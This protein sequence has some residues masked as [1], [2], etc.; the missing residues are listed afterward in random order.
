MYKNVFI[1]TLLVSTL[2]WIVQAK[3]GADS[4]ENP[5]FE[6]TDAVNKQVYEKVLTPESIANGKAHFEQ[7]C[8]ACHGKAL[9]GGVG[10]NLKDN[11]WVHGDTPAQIIA[12]IQT[13]FPNAGMPG[14]G[15][16]YSE[17]QLQDIVAYVLSN[18]E[19]FSN[20]HYT[21]YQLDSADD[22][23]ITEDKRIK[24]GP[25]LTPYADFSM[26]EV[27]H[28]YIEFEGDFYAP[29]TQDTQV[30]LEWGY[31]HEFDLYIDGALQERQGSPW[32]PVWPLKRGKQHVKM[33]Y[34]SGDT[35][36]GQRNLVLLGT[37][38]DLT[39]KLFAMSTRAKAVL[40][41][42]QFNVTVDAQ[43]VVLRKRVLDLPTYT[44]SVGYPQKLNVGF[45]TKTC[46][47][48]GLWQGDLMNIGP[49]ISGRGEDPSIPL[50]DFAFRFPDSLGIASDTPLEQS[51]QYRGYKLLNGNPSFSFSLGDAVY[52]VSPKAINSTTMAFTFTTSSLQEKR[53]LILPESPGISWRYGGPNAP[54]KKISNAQALQFDNDGVAHITATL[55]LSK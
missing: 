29:T 52:T 38:P 8:A 51:C 39:V 17:A 30:W 22:N 1:N 37:N 5:P 16:M 44:I 12:N 9:E 21:L 15:A 32:Y 54:E 40:D 34:R 31:S 18:R 42:K 35:K 24:S 46:Q 7:V 36:P 49:N 53:N 33:T 6:S 45:N 4:A 23:N 25:S 47:I 26:P 50:G 27:A 20:L 19:G 14:F 3:H 13:G 10:F 55:T 41:D 43:P 28:Y 2:L 11:E 48:N